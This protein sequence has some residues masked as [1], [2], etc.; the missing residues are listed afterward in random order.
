MLPPLS[1]SQSLGRT[2]L[3]AIQSMAPS[4]NVQFDPG[5]DLATAAALAASSQVA[6]VFVNQWSSE[7][8]DRTDLNFDGQDDL[9]SSVAA[10]NPHTVVVMENAGAQVMP[11]LSNVSAVLEAWYP[12]Q[13]GAEAIANILFGA[14]N[15]SGKLPITFPA[16][17]ND[18]PH[19]VIATPPD[20]TTPF[21]VSYSE[22]LNVGY[23][24]YNS[25]NITPLFPFG[26]GLSYTTFAFSDVTILNNLSAAN[27]SVQIT[28]ALTNTGAADGA[29]VAQVYVQ[30]PSNLA[31][32]P[33][34][35][36]GWRKVFLAAGARQRVT[37]EI[38]QD[39]SSHPLSWWNPAS[40]AWEIAPG[41]YTFFVGDS[42]G[43]AD[44]T[45]AGTVQLQ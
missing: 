31:E 2:P 39:D 20:G 28:C 35:L 17:V 43:S 15:P 40:N 29:E 24:W 44:L 23:K 38:D 14:V 9:I 30:L 4:A 34:R 45:S 36:I 16:S 18:L 1:R 21:P 8:M 13:R 32:P 6:I 7:G 25:Q 42:S 27:P 11:W 33:L 37:I 26:F 41:A 12:G 5:T 3:L 22:G 19:P 10:A